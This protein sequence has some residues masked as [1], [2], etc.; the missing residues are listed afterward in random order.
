MSFKFNGLS[1]TF[2]F[3]WFRFFFSLSKI[4]LLLLLASRSTNFHLYFIINIHSFQQKFIPSLKAFNSFSSWCMAIKFNNSILLLLIC[5]I[6]INYTLNF[7]N[8]WRVMEQLF[9]KKLIILLFC[10]L[11][12]SNKFIS[13]VSSRF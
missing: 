9:N 6:S 13:S 5:Q 3:L 2:V 12:N 4:L 10:K 1:F 11:W 7:L 8:S